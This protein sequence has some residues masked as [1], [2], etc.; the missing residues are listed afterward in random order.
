MIAHASNPPTVTK[1]PPVIASTNN[2]KPKIL[3]AGVDAGA[4][5]LGEL[6]GP[7]AQAAC[8]AIAEAT[9]SSGM[10]TSRI[11]LALCSRIMGCVCLRSGFV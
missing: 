10:E 7:S 9:H 2:D 4:K 5:M 6:C 11:A 1:I 3:L 8:L